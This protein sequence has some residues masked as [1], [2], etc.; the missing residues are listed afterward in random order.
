MGDRFKQ[1]YRIPSARLQ[2]YD[3][4]QNGAYFITICTKNRFHF[5]GEIIVS[6]QETHT[7]AYLQ[8]T[9]IGEIANEYW[10]KI[11]AHF[12]FVI[13]DEFQ[14]M[15]NHVHGII[16]IDK[17]RLQNIAG[18]ETQNIAGS[19]TQNIA[20]SETQNIA[21]SETQ[22][23]A[24][25]E[26]QNIADSETQNIA[27]S[28][29]QN[30]ADSE[31]QNIAGSETQNVADSE[32]QNVADS[33]TQNIADSETQNIADSETQNIAGSEMQNIAGSETQNIASLQGGYK[34]KFGPQSG[35]LSSVIRGY[36]AAVKSFATSNNIEFGWQPRFHDRIIRDEDE[37]NRIRKYI[38]EN[39]DNWFR[40]YNNKEDLFM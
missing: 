2:G 26:T 15:P 25:S 40:D 1:K 33:E 17:N 12:S 21:G 29:S 32:T 38:V 31:T 3:Y 27:D 37:M 34:N 35:N 9:P 19:E 8:A 14:I 18:S 10:K 13:L 5:F 20:D 7:N 23:I 6:D 39:P 28:E 11:P 36:K 16:I 30:V 24:G 22:N 4:G